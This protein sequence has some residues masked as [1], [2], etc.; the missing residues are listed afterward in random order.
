MR[1]MNIDL[2]RPD[3]EVLACIG[4]YNI[5]LPCSL[6]DFGNSRLVVGFVSGSELHRVHVG[7]LRGKI[8]QR[9]CGRIT[10][11][12]K[13]DGVGACG[14]DSGEAKADSSVGASNWKTKIQ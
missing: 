14:E 8:L 3:G 7:V 2:L 1:Y 12:S 5:Q 11:T 4:D 13:D 6:L 9:L 10:G